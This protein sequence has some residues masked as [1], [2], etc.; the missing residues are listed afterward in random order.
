MSLSGKHDRNETYLQQHRLA[1]ALQAEHS[2]TH[3]ERRRR[4]E[5]EVSNRGNME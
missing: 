3:H 2:I 4:Y 1:L 5:E